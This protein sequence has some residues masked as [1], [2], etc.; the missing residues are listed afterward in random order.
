MSVFRPLV[1]LAALLLLAA[2][3]SET[4][5]KPHTAPARQATGVMTL[6][7]TVPDGQR[8]TIS[9]GRALPLTITTP[10]L[11]DLSA[12]GS[13]PV[14]D[15]FGEDFFRQRKAV[16]AARKKELALRIQEQGAVDPAFGPDIDAAQAVGGRLFPQ[17]VRIRLHRNS[18]RSVASRDQFYA[19][20]AL[21]LDQGWDRIRAQMQQ[22]CGN[23][24]KAG[25]TG[26]ILM[27]A[28]CR[29]GLK[30]LESRHA[31]DR[32]ALEVSRRQSTIR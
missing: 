2:C 22:E 15:C 20:E 24:R 26:L 18:F 23:T 6:I 3:S 16:P 19:Q 32:A 30:R 29:A 5:Q 12:F 8:C 13:A 1:P 14:V 25:T 31:A 21:A 17:R 4:A 7:D 11:V 10:R 28:E 9:G 27:S